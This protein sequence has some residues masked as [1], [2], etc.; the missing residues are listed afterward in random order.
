DFSVYLVRVQGMGTFFILEERHNG[1]GH[2]STV[3]FNEIQGCR[4]SL[5]LYK[6]HRYEFKVPII[7]F[8]KTLGYLNSIHNIRGGF[9]GFPNRWPACVAFLNPIEH[10]FT[11]LSTT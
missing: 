10:F 3:T 9:Y 1:Y 4:I 2:S 5:I 7:I 8:Q 6:V 11:Q